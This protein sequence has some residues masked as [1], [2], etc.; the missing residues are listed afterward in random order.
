MECEKEREYL[1]E[2]KPEDYRSKVTPRRCSGE[3]TSSRFIPANT[4]LWGCKSALNAKTAG[5]SLQK[6]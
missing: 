4:V 5:L 3:Y 2:I 1:Q 6:G